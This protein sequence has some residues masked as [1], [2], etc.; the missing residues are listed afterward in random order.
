MMKTANEDRDGIQKDNEPFVYS[1]KTLV[2]DKEKF[3]I[4]NDKL[5][6]KASNLTKDKASNLTKCNENK[7]HKKKEPAET[8]KKRKLNTEAEVHVPVVSCAEDLIG[9]RICHRFENENGEE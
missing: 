8:G 2:L 7:K 1:S 3:L 4:E 5:C 6:Q 9:K